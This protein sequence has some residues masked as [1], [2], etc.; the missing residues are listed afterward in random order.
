MG[1]ANI[2]ANNAPNDPNSGTVG[3][4]V[5]VVLAGMVVVGADVVVA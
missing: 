4:V 5:V 1:A 3:I 2:A